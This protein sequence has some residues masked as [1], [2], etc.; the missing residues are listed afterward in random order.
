MKMHPLGIP[1]RR[2]PAGVY[3]QG[4]SSSE[5][6]A[7]L[8]LADPP[9]VNLHELRPTVSRTIQPFWLSESPVTNAQ[10][11]AILGTACADEPHKIALL[12]APRLD[13]ILERLG[14]ALPSEAQWEYAQRAGAVA[15]LFPVPLDPP[16]EPKTVASWMSWRIDA[17]SRANAWGL[18]GIF[19]PQWTGSPWHEGLDLGATVVG[20][21][22][23]AVL[24]CRSGG[25]FF[26]PWQDEEWIWCINAMRYP[27]TA[28]LEG[29]AAARVVVSDL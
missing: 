3:E 8:T 6:R 15:S 18:T 27:S 2:I 10:V 22:S 14:A 13:A 5:E 7:L 24:A 21:A 9:Q 11:S 26:W 1:F 17:T 4:L 23:G 19:T 29:E 25:A 28:L 20:R 12:S 16:F